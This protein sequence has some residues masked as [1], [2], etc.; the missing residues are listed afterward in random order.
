VILLAVVT[1]IIATL[2]GLTERAAP[3]RGDLALVGRSLIDELG[4]LYTVK[5]R[6]GTVGTRTPGVLHGF[7]GSASERR[8]HFIAI[9]IVVINCLFKILFR[10]RLFGRDIVQSD[11]AAPVPLKAPVNSIGVRII[12]VIVELIC[13]VLPRGACV[14]LLRKL[15][16]L[17]SSAG[18]CFEAERE[19]VEQH[20]VVQV[21]LPG[22]PNAAL[23]IFSPKESIGNLPL[24]LWI[25]GGGWIGGTA[26]MAARHSQVLA[27]QGFVVASLDYSLAPEQC[28]PTPV[29][30]SMAALDWLKDNAHRFGADPTR[31]VIGGESAGAQLAS[32][33]AALV[34]G[35]AYAHSTGITCTLPAAS[36]RA[37]ILYNGIY[38]MSTFPQC[39]F[40][41]TSL[42]LASYFGRS[43]Y[44]SA[45]RIGE[46][47]SARHATDDFPPTYITA[48]DADPLESESYQMDAVL[49]AHGVT[50]RSRYWTG[51]GL[52]LQH[53]FMSS[54]DSDAA[55]TVLSD[56]VQF[57]EQHTESRHAVQK[58]DSPGV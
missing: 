47:S 32:Q 48:G 42:F 44:R 37:V 8:S 49:R 34:T 20:A 10:E 19:R 7:A 43:D 13:R 36:L 46:L 6:Q 25:H 40:P 16:A 26:A 50:V 2:S 41:L 21:P 17:K 53:G 27:A 52:H 22:L 39:R 38:D 12:F 11:Y 1:N 45:Q 56:T 18:D 54:L 33:V 57:I 58:S 55:C 4:V 30:Q 29:L 14:R 23:T 5:V 35:P 15:F 31:L 28:Y 51:S 9:V 3:Y 24:V